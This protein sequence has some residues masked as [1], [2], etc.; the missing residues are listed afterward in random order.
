MKKGF[1]LA[2]SI[3]VGLG[4]FAQKSPV[5]L[6]SQAE[7]SAEDTKFEISS[8]QKG[9]S[10]F[11]EDFSGGYG[12]W[13]IE[14]NVGSTLWKIAPT[15][16]SPATFGGG[17][18]A[19]AL[20]APTSGNGYAWMDAYGYHVEQ[21]NPS[22]PISLVTSITTP[23]I[24]MSSSATAVLEYYQ[25]FAY[26]C[27]STP[28]PFTVSVSIDGGTSWTLFPGEGNFI[29][30]AN[31]NSGNQLNQLDISC[32]AAGEADVRIRFGYGYAL[33]GTELSGF[34]LY[35][36]GI[37]DINVFGSASVDDIVVSQVTNGDVFNI[38]EYRDTPLQ[39]APT[40]SEGGLLVGVMY[41][42]NGANDQT[43]VTAD[44]SITDGSGAEVYSY[45]SSPFDVLSPVNSL[46]CPYI[47]DTMYFQTGF[48]PSEVGEYNIEVTLAG[49]QTDET[50]DNNTMNRAIG[51]N[52]HT[53][54]HDDLNL[55]DIE[56]EPVA[57]A[58][59]FQRAGYGSFFTVPNDGSFANG[60]KVV[61]GPGCHSEF[62]IEAR[63]YELTAPGPINPVLEVFPDVFTVYEI[64]VENVPTSTDDLIETWIE[65]DDEWELLPG[66]FYFVCVIAEEGTGV[67]GNSPSRLTVMGQ[68]SSDTDF[69]TRIIALSGGDS[70]APTWFTDQG[71]PAVKLTMDNE[72]TGLTEL[73]PLSMIDNIEV[74]PNPASVVAKINFTLLESTDLQYMVTDNTGRVVVLKN[75]G[76]LAPG[77][78]TFDVDVEALSAG[79]Y[80]ISLISGSARTTRPMVIAK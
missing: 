22:P 28:S 2:L 1:T 26:C 63:L 47:M 75:L 15:E 9:N 66:N 50:P 6:D 35:S 5:Q 74:T 4:G 65:F 41:R 21:G 3:M 70:P 71:T 58:D 31:V 45:E 43:G 79:I 78:Q 59:Q 77:F 37:D 17:I 18:G 55:L 7:V 10:L 34:G 36:W 27:F 72:P 11:F 67:E 38:Y 73:T 32:V 39:Q 68:S 80:Q 14:E 62:E 12:D 42:N 13:V 33:D 53:M 69:S 20:T 56:F 51:Y 52:N 48:V 64:D 54:G 30:D 44:I 40:S 60:V 49:D 25:R 8:E 57:N 46:I 16:G 23:S 29:P 24:D 19:L 76:T 61:F